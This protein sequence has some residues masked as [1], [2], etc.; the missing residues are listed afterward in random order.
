MFRYRRSPVLG[1][2]VPVPNG[3]ARMRGRREAQVTMLTFIDL[4]ERVPKDHP[5]R[6][7]KALAEQAL[8][9]LSDT[10]ERCTPRTAD[11]RSRRSGCSRRRS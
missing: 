7:I 3:E 5:L 9:A 4:E 2:N 8:A 11:R 1:Y 10:F 6:T